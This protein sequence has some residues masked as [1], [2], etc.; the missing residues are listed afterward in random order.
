MRVGVVFPGQGSQVLGMGVD[1]ARAYPAAAACFAAAKTLLGYD[2]LQLCK[3]GP[4]ERLRETRYSQPAIFVTNVALARAVGD[5]LAPAVSAGHSF[6]EYCSLTLA[7]SLTFEAALGL[8]NE[9]GLAMHRAAT[10]AQ[11]A[12]AAVLGLDPDALRAAVARAVETGSGRV[13]LANFNAPGQIVI[14]GDAAA[15]RVAGELAVEAGAKRV[16]PLNVSG[17][18]HSVLMDPARV[19]FAP[20]VAAA[21]VRMPHFTVISNV[22]AVPYTD[23]EQI[24]TNLVRSVTDEVRWHD[25]AVAM[26]AL[27]LDLIVEFGASPVL[28]PMFKRI[29]GAPK[30]TTVSDA[31]GVE[32]LRS[33]LARSAPDTLPAR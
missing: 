29:A 13:Q 11:G 33:Q 1:V 15:V 31:A 26:V 8:V 28:A 9:R 27:G 3:D 2:L 25:A 17:A 32:Q 21:A 4:E 24:K 12:M 7:G 18:W 30:A 10:Q 20:H 19:E 16:V 6:G 23:V 5:A 22:D 14:S